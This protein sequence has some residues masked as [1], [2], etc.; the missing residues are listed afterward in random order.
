MIS[1]YNT[2]PHGVKNL[3]QIVAKELHLHGFIVG[4]LRHKYVDEFYTKWVK[5]VASGEIKYKEYFVHGL[6]NAGQGL[7]DVLQ[8]RNFGKCV[9]IVAEQ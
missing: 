3:M 7:S 1:G 5:R 2:Q 9:V 8:G 6:E 4:S